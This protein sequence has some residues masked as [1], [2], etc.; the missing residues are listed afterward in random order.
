MGT[1]T[2]TEAR[3]IKKKIVLHQM[4]YKRQTQTFETNL[5]NKCQ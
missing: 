2:K 4:A 5:F 1:T 3:N